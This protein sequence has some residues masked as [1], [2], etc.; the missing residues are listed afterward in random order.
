LAGKLSEN[1]LALQ[2]IQQR[3]NQQAAVLQKEGKN[4]GEVEKGNLKVFI[5]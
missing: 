2:N 4:I 1:R 5:F 3:L